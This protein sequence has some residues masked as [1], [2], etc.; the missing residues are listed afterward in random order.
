MS[1]KAPKGV[2]EILSAE[3]YG[4][5][6][7]NVLVDHLLEL[8]ESDRNRIFNLGYYTWVEQQGINIQ[9]FE[10]RRHQTFWNQLEALIPTW[11]AMIE[12]FNQETAK[13]R[14]A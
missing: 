1:L 3:L 6:L 11:D 5:H 14:N 9:D 8:T 12:A 7:K 4:A 13:S 10:R 2:D